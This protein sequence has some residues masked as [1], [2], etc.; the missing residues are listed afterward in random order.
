[1]PAEFQVIKYTGKDCEFGTPVS[2]IGLKRI[3]A[4][5]PA[6]YGDPIVPGDDITDV[7]TYSI[8]RPDDENDTTYSFES[9]FKLKLKTPP[10]NQLSNIRIYPA[11]DEP[12]DNNK[13]LLFIGMSQSYSRPTNNGSLVATNSIWNYTQDAPFLVTVGGE[14]GQTPDEQVSETNY[15]ITINDIG[16]GNLIYLNEERQLDVPIVEGNT[17]QF[18]DKT[19]DTVEFTV[20]DPDTDLAIS[21]SDIVVSIN[22][23]GERVVTIN[24]TSAL[25]TSYPNGFKYGDVSDI[26]IGSTISILDLS[27]DPIEIV[28]YTVEVETLESGQ[29]VYFLNGVR[30]PELNFRKNRLY[31]FT[32]LSGATDPIRFLDNASSIIANVE[33]EIIIKGITVTDGATANEVVLVDPNAINI[34]GQSALSYQS[35]NHAGYGNIITNIDTSLIGNYNINTVNGGTTNPLAAGETDFIYLQLKVTGSSTVGN[36][37]P[38]IIIEYDEN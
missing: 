11:I 14:M 17:Y 35:V 18:V 32:N 9:I 6:V 23:S 20:Y 8:Y 24:A 13:A 1:M 37:V 27:A 3:D 29:K 16:T 26:T 38:E 34:A 2:S 5:V 36:A 31:R 15:N 25:L 28:D 4:A 10:D 19:S 21:D 33:N 12:D 22:G 30:N 7:N